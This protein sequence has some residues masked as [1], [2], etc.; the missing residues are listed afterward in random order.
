MIE[1]SEPGG[2]KITASIGTASLIKE[3]DEE[4]DNLYKAADSAVYC[5]KEN[6][7]N[8]VTADPH[9]LDDAELNQASNQ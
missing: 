1:L 4:F 8:R 5:S 6:G 9:S 3:H 7:R 2:L